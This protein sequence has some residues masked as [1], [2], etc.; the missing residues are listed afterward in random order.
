MHGVASGDAPG[1][2]EFGQQLLQ[3]R[4]FVGSLVDLEVSENQPRFDSEGAEHLFG[5][6]VFEIVEAAL[7]RLAVEGDDAALGRVGREIEDGGAFARR[8]FDIGG[9]EPPQNI[10]NGGM[11]R[12]LSNEV[13]GHVFE[14][15]EVFWRVVGARDIRRRERASPSPSGGCFQSP[16]DHGSQV[17]PHWR[18]RLGK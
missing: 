4:E 3:G 12:R 6:G 1:H 8:L 2:V 14:R 16:S 10:A 11:R 15:S 7:Q 13:V 9:A 5:L 17:R 18:A